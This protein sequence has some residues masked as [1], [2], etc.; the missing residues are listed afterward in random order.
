MPTW[1]GT[2]HSQERPKI[3]LRHPLSAT[4]HVPSLIQATPLALPLLC[5]PIWDRTSWT[6]GAAGPAP[7][8]AHPHHLTT[9]Q[10]H[11]PQPVWPGH[12]RA[13]KQGVS[14]TA[15]PPIA[16]RKSGMVWLREDDHSL[17]RFPQV[18]HTKRTTGTTA[19]TICH[20][21]A[22]QNLHQWQV[23]AAANTPNKP[24]LT[25]TTTRCQNGNGNGSGNGNAQMSNLYI[26]DNAVSLTT[27][28]ES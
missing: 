7:P 5:P 15:A 6:T 10:A 27:V 16:Q 17:P 19:R 2:R 28:W 21:A 22:R 24:S 12:Q 4:H 1:K 14:A 25:G 18:H 3:F 13:V 20:G 11:L 23:Q 9:G 26:I 8:P